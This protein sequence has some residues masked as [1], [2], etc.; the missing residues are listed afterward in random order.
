MK[1]KI[2]CLSLCVTLLCL[3]AVSSVSSVPPQKPPGGTQLEPGPYDPAVD[4]D[5]DKYISSWK[6]SPVLREN[7]S[8]L[9]LLAF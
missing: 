9:I 2:C 4:P 3:S 7:S 1:T 5:C 6:N 8:G